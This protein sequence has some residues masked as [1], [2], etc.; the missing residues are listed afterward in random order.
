MNL[1]N[2]KKFCK[3]L[4]FLYFKPVLVV[5]QKKPKNTKN[6]RNFT[7]ISLTN[8]EVSAKIGLFGILNNKEDQ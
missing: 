2:K 4:N 6:N 1:N 7:S 3:R 5:H 8:E